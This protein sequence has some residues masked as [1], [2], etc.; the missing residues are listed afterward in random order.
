MVYII[1][2]DVRNITGLTTSDISDVLISSTIVHAT[3]QLNADIQIKVDDERIG[4]LD[5]ERKNYVNSSNVTYYLRGKYVGDYDNNGYVSGVDVYFYKLATDGTRNQIIVTSVDDFNTSQIT[6]ASA[7]LA[8]DRVFATYYTSP[9]QLTPPHQ[10][11]KLACA[12]LSAALCYTRIDA[13]KIQSFRVGKV[14][15]SK[16]SEAFNTFYKQ[17]KDTI[18][19]IRD[20]ILK[21]DFSKN[22]I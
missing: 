19:R 17:Y 11:I 16:Q 20:H 14:A 15:V 2:T 4:T 22:V 9:V 5:N 7:P 6:V 1:E 3:A 8:S 18:N 13:N 12:Q 10:L 21:I